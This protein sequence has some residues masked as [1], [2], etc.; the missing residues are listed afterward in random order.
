MSTHLRLCLLSECSCTSQ[1]TWNAPGLARTCGSVRCIRACTTI[2]ARHALLSSLLCTHGLQEFK[3]KIL[4]A[5][6]LLRHEQR[7]NLLKVGIM[8]AS[9]SPHV[10]SRYTF[11]T[12]FVVG[13]HRCEGPGAAI[14]RPMAICTSDF[15]EIMCTRSP[16]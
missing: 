11:M 13:V 8:L 1:P 9:M 5:L 4:R 12:A 2:S 10:H 14:Q 6:R 15:L 7:M 16:W 3:I